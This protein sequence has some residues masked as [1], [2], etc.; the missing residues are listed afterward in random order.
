MYVVFIIVLAAV[1]QLA[2]R[3]F[4]GT[5]GGGPDDP[6][7]VGPV[8]GAIGMVAGW[9]AVVALHVRG[10]PTRTLGTAHRP[11]ARTRVGGCTHA[12]AVP[13]E[14]VVTG[15]VLAALCPV[16]D[17]QL[18]AEALTSSVAFAGLRA[19]TAAIHGILTGLDTQPR[20][21]HARPTAIATGPAGR[22]D[23]RHEH[24]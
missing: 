10:R 21:A 17:A 3:V 11:T 14:S 8:S 20:G 16:C 22:K 24:L 18:P 7:W 12:Q 1:D 19:D 6:L 2:V 15:Q 23:G 5:W 4:T 13:V 9:A